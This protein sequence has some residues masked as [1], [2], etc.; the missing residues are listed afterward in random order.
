MW[1]IRNIEKNVTLM[2]V[3]WQTNWRINGEQPQYEIKMSQRSY[4][5]QW[6]M[7]HLY[8]LQHNDLIIE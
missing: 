6:T 8:G 2:H 1:K 3:T 4:I 7:A 5:P